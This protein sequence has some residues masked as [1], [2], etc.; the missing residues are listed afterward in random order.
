MLLTRTVTPPSWAWYSKQCIAVSELHHTT[1]GNHMPC[2]IT[3]CYLLP[4]RLTFLP[5]P[6]PKLVLDGTQHSVRFDFPHHMCSLL[7]LFQTGQGWCQE[8]LHKLGL[9]K[10]SSCNC[11]QW[12]TV[13]HIVHMCPLTNF[14]VILKLLHEANDDTVIWLEST[15]VT[16]LAKWGWIIIDAADKKYNFTST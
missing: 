9:A 6:Q 8:N 15:A 12:Q 2:G 10:S 7:S 14:K 5:L 4:D 13:N 11:G 16:A 1:T 3:R